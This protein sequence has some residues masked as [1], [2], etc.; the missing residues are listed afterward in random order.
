MQI[1]EALE[2]FLSEHKARGSRPKTIRYYSKTLAIVLRPVLEHSLD[3]LTVFTVNKLLQAVAERNLKPATLASYDRALRGFCSWLVGVELLAKNPMQGKKRPKLRWEPKAVLTGEE[4]Q[5]LFAVAKADKRYRDR[6][7]AILYLLLGC[8]LRAGEVAKLKLTDI[9]WQTGII[10]VNGKVGYGKIPVTKQCLQAMRRY[11]TH[12]RKAQSSC[13]WLFVYDGRG[14]E[15]HTVSKLIARMGRRAGLDRNIGPHLLR[16]SMAS[17]FIANGGDAFTLRR[18]LR[19]SS[20]FT[21]S[22]YVSNSTANLR[23]KLEIY[24]PLKGV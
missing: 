19:H 13:Q 21:T 12:S 10:E 17:E 22:L 15:S 1:A 7:V 20:L 4:I 5:K 8:G 24:G 23:D 6:N 2:E 3:S 16:H 9:D 11:V 14:I 18:L